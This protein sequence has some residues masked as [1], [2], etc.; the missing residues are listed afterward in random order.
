MKK[1]KGIALLLALSLC[2]ALTSCGKSNTAVYVQSVERLSSLGGIAPG[3]RFAGLVVSENVSELKRDAEKTIKELMVREGD[4]VKEGQELFAYDTEELQL[5]LDKLLLEKEQL[6]ST[7]ENLTKQIA[8]LERVLP[9]VSANNKLQYT[10]EVQTM[11]VDL[12][13]AELNIKLKENEIKKSED[14][15][16][17]AVVKAPVTGRVQSI[18]EN[19]TDNQGKPLP[20][21][22]IQQAGSYRIKGT[23]GELQRGAILEGNRLRIFSR[24]REE[25]SWSGTVTLVDYENPTQGSQNDMYM[26]TQTDEM[27]ASSKYP[28]YVEL[29]DTE[30]LILGQHV[31]MELQQEDGAFVG[32]SIGG[33]FVCYDENSAPYVWAEKNGKLEKRAVTLG[34]YNAMQDSFQVLEGLTMEDY[35]AFPDPELCVE[36]APTSHDQVTEATAAPS[37]GGVA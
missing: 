34:E 17:N 20:Y 23:L 21:I 3:D 12:K 5:A 29:D 15:L 36:G 25:D 16:A 35:I 27:T 28:F 18:N 6:K 7:I 33:S 22:T 26:G 8:E 14:L 13:E 1:M 32:P 9:T 31:Y 37:E 4:D 19:T 30:G 2:A 10:L 24:T 11:Q